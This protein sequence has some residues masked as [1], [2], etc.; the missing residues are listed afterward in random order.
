MYRHSYTTKKDS[1]NYKITLVH[2]IGRYIDY[3]MILYMN[4]M[5]Q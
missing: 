2:W 3:D 4:N 5:T 1:T